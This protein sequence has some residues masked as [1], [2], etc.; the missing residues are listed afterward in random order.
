[1]NNTIEVGSKW[2]SD[3][4]L[5]VTVAE[6]SER[7]PGNVVIFYTEDLTGTRRSFGKIG[8]LSRFTKV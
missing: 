3:R 7:S 4:A 1:M 8:F 2:I 5:A 6:I